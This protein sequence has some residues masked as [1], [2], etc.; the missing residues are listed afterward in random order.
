MDFVNERNLMK[1]GHIERLKIL[2]AYV[3]G[4]RRSPELAV[5]IWKAKEEGVFTYLF[6]GGLS[7][8]GRPGVDLQK[9]K[10]GQP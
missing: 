8:S 7:A 9:R 10:S 6:K 4:G 2:A 5:H 3:V 1:L